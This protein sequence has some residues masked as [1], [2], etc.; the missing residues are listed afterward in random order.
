MDQTIKAQWV[1]ALRSGEYE[2]GRGTLHNPVANEYCCLGVLCDLAVRA[3]VD[4]LVR[5][6]NTLTEYDDMAGSL[7]Y[8]VWEWAGLDSNDPEIAQLRDPEGFYYWDEASTL[9]DGGVPFTQIADLIDWA[10]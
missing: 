4:V 1:A 2:Q 5:K 8:Q 3:G 7:P 10:L 9:N 6:L